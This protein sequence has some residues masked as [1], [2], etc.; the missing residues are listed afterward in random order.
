V[1]VTFDASVLS[2][3]PQRRRLVL[4]V[5]SGAAAAVDPASA[6]GRALSRTPGS[7]IVADTELPLPAGR[8]IV[9]AFGKA[10]PA[11]AA[12]ALETLQGLK[13]T[14][15]VVS[16]EP[17]G[18]P[19]LTNLV[20]SHPV[21]DAGSLRAGLHLL[22]LATAAGPDDLVLALVSG[23]GSSLA[24][25]PA[26]GLSL[27]DIQEVSRLLLRSGAPISEVNTVRRHLSRLK[28]GRLATAAYPARITTLMISDVVGSPLEAIAGGPTVADP[29]SPADA[30]AVLE[31]WEVNPPPE[32]LSH[33]RQGIGR[34][35]TPPAGVTPSADGPVLVVADA[36]AAAEGARKAASSLGLDA[37]VVSTTVEGS[38][39]RVGRRLAADAV[40]LA[41]GAMGIYAG[42][43]T[44]TVTGRGRGGR[45]QELALAAGIALASHPGVLVA[46]FATDGVDGPTDAAGGIGDSGTVKRG[47]TAG[48]DAPTALHD[49]D[50]GTYL[51]ATGDLLRC[52]PTGTN[53]GDLMITLRADAPQA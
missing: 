15:V 45:N 50:S 46:S 17:A 18:L 31:R 34:H 9:L 10:A 27:A 12:A 6:V 43:T 33:L 4:D 37:R 3:D 42:E 22:H 44:V 39:R 1:T 52:G 8:V 26:D 11:M 19:G 20:G 21:P 35:S 47:R 7:L 53:V 30:L 40:A 24:E 13:V 16:Q 23:G 51:E 36:A 41:G 28:G 2:P 29:T 14:G 32:V 38:A 49:N 25:V 48:I 5:L